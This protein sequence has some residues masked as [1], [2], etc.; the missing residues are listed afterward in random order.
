MG[1]IGVI[2]WKKNEREFITIVSHVQYR[3]EI[4]DFARMHS[5]YRVEFCH[6]TISKI[7][8]H[9]AGQNLGMMEAMISAMRVK[10]HDGWFD[11]SVSI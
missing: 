3:Y 2:F 9:P 10:G 7:R 4:S 1:T 11:K 8:T 6:H 5:A